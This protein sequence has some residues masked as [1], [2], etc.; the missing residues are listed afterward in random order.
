MGILSRKGKVGVR[1][2]GT[3]AFMERAKKGEEVLRHDAGGTDQQGKVR[4]SGGIVAE[5]RRLERGQ[6]GECRAKLSLRSNEDQAGKDR[7]PLASEMIRKDTPCASWRH[8]FYGERNRSL[9]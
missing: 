7:R 8:G 6:G 3:S 5:G 9:S 1:A 2:Q 4:L